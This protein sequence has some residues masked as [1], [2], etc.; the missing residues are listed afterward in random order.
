MKENARATYEALL[1][2]AGLQVMFD[3][4]FVPG[5]LVAFH[6]DNENIFDALGILSYQTKTFW[7]GVDSKTIQVAP[8][9]NSSRN[10]LE[11]K[12]QKSVPLINVQS[13]QH[14]NDIVNTIRQ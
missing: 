1:Q 2:A 9:T 11:P 6:V 12:I 14:I 10:E 8:A 7:R 5:G 3:S 4:R 13:P